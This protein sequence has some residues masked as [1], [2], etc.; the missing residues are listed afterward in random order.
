VNPTKIYTFMGAHGAGK[1]FLGKKLI[2]ENNHYLKFTNLPSPVSMFWKSISL[3]NLQKKEVW[4]KLD[5]QAS[6]LGALGYQLESL[7]KYYANY[8]LDRSPLDV[9][10]YSL[11]LGK[12]LDTQLFEYHIRYMKKYTYLLTEKF[13]ST[14]VFIPYQ[15]EIVAHG[16]SESTE[17]KEAQ[18]NAIENDKLMKHVVAKYFLEN[19]KRY[20]EQLS[21]TTRLI[22]VSG[23]TRNRID[24]I[25]QALLTRDIEQQFCLN[26]FQLE[27]WYD[28]TVPVY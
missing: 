13:V 26:G 6:V 24:Q 10:A 25:K 2:E 16:R 1:T 3:T 27:D 9:I 11:M 19:G 7:D 18:S 5:L 14:I 21:K 22:I 28:S 8:L 15:E 17:Y 4:E 23:N 12:K 20:P